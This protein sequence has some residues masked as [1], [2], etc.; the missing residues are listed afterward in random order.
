MLRFASANGSVFGPYK[1]VSESSGAIDVVA[2]Q[3]IKL[4]DLE[5]INGKVDTMSKSGWQL[6]VA[7]CLRTTEGGF[8]SGV[9]LAVRSHIG[10]GRLGMDSH[11]LVPGRV[12]F[13]HCDCFKKRGGMFFMILS[14]HAG[15]GLTE[16][17]KAILQTAGAFVRDLRVPWAIGGDFNFHPDVLAGSMGCDEVGGLIICTGRDTCHVKG[18]GSEL[19]YFLVCR[20]LEAFMLMVSSKP[21]AS[22]KVHDMVEIAFQGCANKHFKVVL[23]QPRQFPKGAPPTGQVPHPRIWHG[24]MVTQCSTLDFIENL[25]NILLSWSQAAE[26][27]LCDLHQIPYEERSRH[28]GR[29][30][31]P[32]FITVPVVPCSGGSAFKI[33]EQARAARVISTRGALVARA[34]WNYA[35]LNSSKGQLYYLDCCFEGFSNVATSEFLDCVTSKVPGRQQWRPTLLYFWSQIGFPF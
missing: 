15:E 6:F 27:G 2:G 4:L 12:F 5:L 11:V 18:S 17:N 24:H 16:K 14:L 3:E 8:S 21:E 31:T 19:D 25:P 30:A 7:P 34:A 1:D 13:V 32:E 33:S 26:Q 9:A 23:E 10:T 22:I 20:I 28:M 35:N 29:G